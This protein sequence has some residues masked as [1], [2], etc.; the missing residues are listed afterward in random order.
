MK[1][2]YQ[3]VQRILWFHDQKCRTPSRKTTRSFKYM[4]RKEI[5]CWLSEA[6]GPMFLLLILCGCF[7]AEGIPSTEEKQTS[8]ILTRLEAKLEKQ[9][10]KI[11]NQE[12]KI[13]KSRGKGTKSRGKDKK[14][15]GKNSGARGQDREAR[16]CDQ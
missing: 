4:H 5:T 12:A 1:F 7:L 8:E 16:C 6:M 10:A 15:R 3:I 11:E 9:E 14:P 13:K 2:S